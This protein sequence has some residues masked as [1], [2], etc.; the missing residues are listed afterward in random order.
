MCTVFSSSLAFKARQPCCSSTYTVVVM[1]CNMVHQICTENVCINHMHVA[2][3]T[4]GFHVYKV[5]EGMP[6][7]QCGQILV[8]DRILQV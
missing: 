8:G 6:A 2:Y 1:M 3:D 4:Q 5:V 7:A